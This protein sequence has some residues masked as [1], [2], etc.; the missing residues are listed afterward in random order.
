MS[1][2]KGIVLISPSAFAPWTNIQQYNKHT[3]SGLAGWATFDAPLQL[4]IGATLTNLSVCLTDLSD[5]AHIMVY[6]ER[7]NITSP[8]HTY[9]LMANVSTTDPQTIYPADQVVLYNDTINYAKIDEN[10]FY[11]LTA[12]FSQYIYLETVNWVQIEYEYLP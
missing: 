2:Q 9:E 10:C 8:Y 6:L 7:Y 4:P 5:Q 1:P 11:T 12:D 3:V